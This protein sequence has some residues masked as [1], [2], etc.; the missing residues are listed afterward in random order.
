M[1][2]AAFDAGNF[3]VIPGYPF[4]ACKLDN[5]KNVV[6][7]SMRVN[8]NIDACDFVI[9]IIGS[10]CIKDY[11][12]VICQMGYKRRERQIT[13]HC[14]HIYHPGCGS[15]WLNI[16]KACPIATHPNAM[17][18][19]SRYFEGQFTPIS[20]V[21]DDKYDHETSDIKITKADEKMSLDFLAL[22]IGGDNIKGLLIS[23]EQLP[24][25]YL[26]KDTIGCKFS[27]R[28]K[29]IRVCLRLMV[30]VNSKFSCRGIRRS[31]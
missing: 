6:E 27:P 16:N 13:L 28:T 26:K 3:F 18:L 20:E 10:V 25:K 11:R 23:P 4:G 31:P 2:Y 21:E 9:V 24:F 5:S 15:Q 22:I 19:L 29:R 7:E 8:M 1:Y 12:F 30:K 14:K 17:K